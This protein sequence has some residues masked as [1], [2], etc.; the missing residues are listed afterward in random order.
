MLFFCNVTPDLRHC[1]LPQCPS[2]LSFQRARAS[3]VFFTGA[4]NGDA[5]PAEVDATAVTTKSNDLLAVKQT[6][7]RN[8]ADQRRSFKQFTKE[9]S[10]LVD[11]VNKGPRTGLIPFPADGIACRAMVF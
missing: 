3:D 6:A 2:P 10:T 4:S 7:A 8:A 5:Q 11:G 9:V 1:N